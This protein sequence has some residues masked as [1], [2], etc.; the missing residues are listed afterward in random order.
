MIAA[1]VSFKIDASAEAD[2]R[3]H[4]GT[5][6]HQFSPP[7]ST[8][9]DLADYSRKLRANALTVEAWKG[10]TLVGLVAGYLNAAERSAYVTNVSV[11]EEFAGKAIATRLLGTFIEHAQAAALGTIA[12]EVSRTNTAAQHL[13]SKFGFR[14]VEDRGDFLLM[15]KPVTPERPAEPIVRNHDREHQDNETRRYAYDFDDVIRKYLLRRLEPH[16]RRDGPALELGCYKGDMTA[17]I[18]EYF[19]GVTVI[20]A[21]GELA[22]IVRERFAG[23]VT[24]ITS[25]F[26]DAEIDSKFDN[27]FI[28]HTLEHLDDPVGV[29]AKVRD[30]LSPEGR[31]FVAVP[32]ANALSRQIAVKMGLVEAN[33]AVTP[34]EAL[35]GH[36]RTYSMDVLLAHVRAAGY[37]VDDHGGILV[38]PLANFQFDKAIAQGIVDD[39]Y[40]DA[41]HELAQTYPDLSATLFA[42]CAHPGA[43][44][45][46]AS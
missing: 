24:V 13:F 1:I 11:F 43:P 32:N 40:L 30:W 8:R 34:A 23:K 7:L 44:A 16:L 38:K 5:C 6:D 3:A 26:E 19:P 33:S 45:A 21:S 31:L 36:R 35:H 29:L 46:Q 39:A 42:V 15:L 9:V 27:I 25:S 12:L 41:C 28:I 4:L 20:E 37:R 18:L 10:K 17:R 14:A 22:Q 2:I